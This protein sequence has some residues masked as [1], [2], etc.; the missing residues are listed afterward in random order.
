MGI[1]SSLA[2]PIPDAL[3]ALVM[4]FRAWTFFGF[5]ALALLDAAAA[6]AVSGRV[7]HFIVP[8][9]PGASTDFIARL[10]AAQI[11]AKERADIVVENRPGASGMIGTEFV[12]RQAPDGNT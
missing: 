9:P 4:N 8:V 3:R 7:I 6:S 10:M 5:L 11:G 1:S 12:S 2:C